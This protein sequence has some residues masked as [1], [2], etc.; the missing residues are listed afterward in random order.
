VAKCQAELLVEAYAQVLRTVPLPYISHLDFSWIR[1]PICGNIPSGAMFTHTVSNNPI[2]IHF[3]P[4]NPA[5]PVI[6]TEL[7]LVA[8]YAW[9]SNAYPA[10][11]YWIEM[12][13]ASGDPAAACCSNITEL[14]NSEINPD[15]FASSQFMIFEEQ[16]RIDA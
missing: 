14:Q 1:V 9:D 4:R 3:S 16:H 6:T 15:A 5:E 8:Q 10:N 11:E 13:S 7:L 2:Q 12:L